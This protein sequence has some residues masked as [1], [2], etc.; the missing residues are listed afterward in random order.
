LYLYHRLLQI[1]REHGLNGRISVNEL[2]FELSKVYMVHY[3][4]D[5]RGLSEIPAKAEK[6]GRLF[7][8]DL[9][10]KKL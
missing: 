6:L 5:A 1:L 10:P 4:D 9:F 3:Q 7:N 2:L 8:F